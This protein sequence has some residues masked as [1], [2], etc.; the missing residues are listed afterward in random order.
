MKQGDLLMCRPLDALIV[1]A[2]ITLSPPIAVQLGHPEVCRAVPALYSQLQ[3]Q[4]THL[5]DDS[6]VRSVNANMRHHSRQPANSDT[7][8]ARNLLHNLRSSAAMQ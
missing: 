6:L 4:N 8:A 1:L 2:A 3:K 7:S 5:N